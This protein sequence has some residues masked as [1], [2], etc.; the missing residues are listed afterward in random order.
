[1]QLRASTNTNTSPLKLPR[2]LH[3]RYFTRLYQ[4]QHISPLSYPAYFTY[5]GNTHISSMSRRTGFLI[6]VD[7]RRGWADGGRLSA[8]SSAAPRAAASSALQR[9]M[10]LARVKFDTAQRRLTVSADLRP[11]TILSL[12][13]ESL[14]VS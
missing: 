10:A 2:V 1:M 9:V 6:R 13:I 14:H 5:I 8:R 11:M 4:H 7:R 3:I 12:I